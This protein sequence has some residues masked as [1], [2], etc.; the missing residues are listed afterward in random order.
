MKRFLYIIAVLVVTLLFSSCGTETVSIEDCEWKM[1]TVMR[2]NIDA[3]QNENDFVI[4]VGEADEVYPDAK[5]VE[6]TLTAK[7]GNLIVTD[8]TN[9][10]KYDGTYEVMKETPKSVDY[11]VT[12]HGTKG[13]ATVAPTEHYDGTE[14][15]TLPINLGEYSLY[16]VPKESSNSN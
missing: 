5:I 2:N 15:P 14:I 12:I 7:E 1:R 3:V 10:K 9:G 16:F 6:L 4:V 8:V 11:E 13:Y